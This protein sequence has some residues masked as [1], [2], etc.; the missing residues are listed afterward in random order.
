ML[1]CAALIAYVCSNRRETAPEHKRNKQFSAYGNH[2]YRFF[3]TSFMKSNK[4]NTY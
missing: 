3:H 1:L 2:K 4:C